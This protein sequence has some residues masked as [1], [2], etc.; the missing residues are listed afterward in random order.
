MVAWLPQSKTRRRTRRAGDASRELNRA[1]GH[2][3]TPVSTSSASRPNPPDGATTGTGAPRP[4]KPRMHRHPSNPLRSRHTALVG[5]NTRR[6]AIGAVGHSIDRRTACLQSAGLSGCAPVAR[7]TQIQCRR[8]YPGKPS[9]AARVGGEVV[10]T[11][12]DCARVLAIR[13]GAS[14]RVIPTIE[15]L[16]SMMLLGNANIPRLGQKWRCRPWRQN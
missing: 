1:Y 6:S 16:M 3:P 8:T 12:G 2:R 15:F 13:P 10:A 11:W 4:R 14:S 9:P 7:R 5:G